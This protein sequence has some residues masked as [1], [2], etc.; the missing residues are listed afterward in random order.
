MPND[1]TRHTF[2]ATDSGKE[3]HAYENVDEMFKA[4]DKF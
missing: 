4:L 1:T 2:D 3:L